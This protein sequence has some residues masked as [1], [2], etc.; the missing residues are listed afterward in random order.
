MCLSIQILQLRQDIKRN[1]ENVAT[2]DYRLMERAHEIDESFDGF[3]ARVC[4][5]LFSS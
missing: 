4:I 2:V 5:M 3:D 1:D